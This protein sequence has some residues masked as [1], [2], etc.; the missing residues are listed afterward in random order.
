MI[1]CSNCKKNTLESSKC[2]FRHSIGFLNDVQVF[3]LTILSVLLHDQMQ[4]VHSTLLQSESLWKSP[5]NSAARQLASD[6]TL[7]CDSSALTV[8]GMM[9]VTRSLLLSTVSVIFS[10]LVVLL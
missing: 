7:H 3:V 1:L 5:A 8:G 6:L 4:K 10:Y 2:L 9:T